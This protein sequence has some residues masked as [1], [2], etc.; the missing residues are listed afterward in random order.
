MDM[1]KILSVIIITGAVFLAVVSTAGADGSA[2][3]G[4]TYNGTAAAVTSLPNT[5]ILSKDLSIFNPIGP[6]GSIK[7]ADII[8]GTHKSPESSISNNG[9]GKSTEAA[10][11]SAE[12]VKTGEAAAGDRTGTAGTDAEALLRG[13][14]LKFVQSGESG[15]GP[16]LIQITKPSAD[17]TVYKDAYSICGVRSDEVMSEETIVVYLARYNAETQLYEFFKDVDGFDNWT[18]G[19]NGVFTKSVLLSNGSNKFAIAAYKVT[20]EKT[21]KPEDVQI[22]KFDIVFKGKNTVLLINEKLKELTISTIFKEI[23]NKESVL[24]E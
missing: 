15:I 11:R 21:L 6:I 10:G 2:V 18:I 19:L 5:M 12:T 14:L 1:K 20:A 8:S 13:T 24:A 4:N 9:S 17:E 23:E 7:P 22:L 3:S 16:S